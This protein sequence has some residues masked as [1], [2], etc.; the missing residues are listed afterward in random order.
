M[1]NGI[2]LTKFDHVINIIQNFLNK[3]INEPIEDI[4]K[5]KIVKTVQT[6]YNKKISSIC[7]LKDK[8]L[9]SSS[10]DGSITVYNSSYESQFQIK[11]SHGS[12]EVYSLCVL[13]EGELVS[14]A[15]KEIKIWEI[16]YDYYELIHTL[17][18]HTDLVTKVIE[19]KNGN[20]CSCSDDKTIK[21]WD[22]KSYYECIKTLEGHTD[23]IQ[24]VI[25]LNDFIISAS[26]D[27]TLRIWNQSVKKMNVPLGIWNEQEIKC[28]ATINDVQCSLSP[29]TLSK[30]NGIT[31]LVGGKNVISIVNVQSFK[32]KKFKDESL[33]KIYCL[34]WK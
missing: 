23:N 14:S 18:D 32:V 8:R 19:L 9:V 15:Y 11:N 29:Y 7:E 21:I 1:V 17:T 13:R 31:L 24:S 26:D 33:G 10:W 25:E 4:S 20:L 2:I 30:L 5:L 3:H 16:N 27:E 34:N 28:I 6:E 22:N 12:N